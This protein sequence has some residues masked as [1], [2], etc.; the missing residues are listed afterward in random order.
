MF[1]V[2]NQ[3]SATTSN[4]VDTIDSFLLDAFRCT[5]VSTRVRGSVDKGWDEDFTPRL[6]DIAT[7][8]KLLLQ[9]VTGQSGQDIP[10]VVQDFFGSIERGI[11]EPVDPDG[12]VNHLKFFC[13]NALEFARLEE[14][15]PNFVVGPRVAETGPALYLAS[16]NISEEI[17]HNAAVLVPITEDIR[18]KLRGYWNDLHSEYEELAN[19]SVGGGG[20]IVNFLTELW[21]SLTGD[22]GD[23]EPDDRF[24]TIHSDQCKLYFYPRISG[25]DTIVNVL[26][27]IEHSRRHV[28]SPCTVR[29]VTPRFRDSRVAVAKAL[30]VLHGNGARIEVVT[31][32]QD[33]FFGDPPKPELG[34]RVAE[35]LGRCAY[36]YFQRS[37]DGMNIHSKYL[38][39]D[40]PYTSKGDFVRQKLVWHGT[41]NMTSSGIDSHWEML[42]KLYEGT[43][44]YDAFLQ[45]FEFLKSNAASLASEP[46]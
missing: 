31:R 3:P 32:S 10:A 7:V 11:A 35:I 2:F 40:A 25:I 16:A 13:F 19:R 28:D 23:S 14:M 33:D 26:E 4:E 30:E 27:N 41:A 12:F 46:E 17:K 43:G 1:A 34:H 8:R 9:L 36:L 18:L 15:H 21:E 39:V 37:N 45:D 42:M 44:A 29:L 38:L 6:E 22:S 24:D 5:E 20:T